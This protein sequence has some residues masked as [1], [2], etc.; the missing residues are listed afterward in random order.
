MH[1]VYIRISTVQL[2]S[3]DE[4]FSRISIELI[5]KISTIT[6]QLNKLSFL[7]TNLHPIQLLEF[8]LVRVFLLVSQDSGPEKDFL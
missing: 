7:P 3:N 8:H 5:H 6:Y 4:V 1:T 2:L